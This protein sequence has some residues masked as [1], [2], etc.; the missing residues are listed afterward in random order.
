VTIPSFD[1]LL[2]SASV[3]AVHLEMREVYTVASEQERIA[4]W[5]EGR[6]DDPSDRASWW[7]PWHDLVAETADRGVAVRR[8]RVVSEPLTEYLRYCH[9]VTFKN[10]LAGEQVRWLPR[11]N[12]SDIALPGN[13]FWLIDDRLV[14][15]NHFDGDGHPADQE[16]TEAHSTVKLCSTAF[17][18]VWKRAIDHQD[19]QP[20]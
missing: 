15:F 4:A 3:S 12:A 16:I 8:A 20:T 13:D 9:A 11:R 5:R 2:R 18:A 10:V 1:E 17:E 19:Y 6:R 14:L 7:R